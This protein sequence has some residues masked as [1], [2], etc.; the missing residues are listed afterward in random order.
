MVLED[1]ADC[2]DDVMMSRLFLRCIRSACAS[3]RDKGQAAK[4]Y[5]EDGARGL[6]VDACSSFNH[7]QALS[8]GAAKASRRAG[9]RNIVGL[10]EDDE[11]RLPR[12]RD[13]LE[14]VE[15]EGEDVVVRGGDGKVE[16]EGRGGEYGYGADSESVTEEDGPMDLLM[17]RGKFAREEVD[18]V[19]ERDVMG[20]VS[21]DGDEESGGGED[22]GSTGEGGYDRGSRPDAVESGG[23]EV[24]F[25][26]REVDAGGVVAESA[27]NE[28]FGTGFLEGDTEE[29]EE[30]DED[31]EEKEEEEEE[32]EEDSDVDRIERLR[33]K[34]DGDRGERGDY[35]DSEGKSGRNVKEFGG[36]AVKNYFSAVKPSNSDSETVNS[37]G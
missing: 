27:R 2:T 18:V 1:N 11:E 19:A 21:D 10:W 35:S 7:V 4:G 29:E 15:G 31:E 13:R 9:G 23:I 33:G 30:E 20:G 22:S 16:G 3:A 14:I 32:E 8:V 28:E 25:G 37:F 5:L 24:G 6:E 17:G 12:L 36:E 34:D 26:G